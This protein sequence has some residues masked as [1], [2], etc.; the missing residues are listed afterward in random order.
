MIHDSENTEAAERVVRQFEKNRFFEGKL[1]TARDMQIEQ[2]YHTER[3][4]LLT[5]HTTGSGIV[6]GLEVSEIQN[7]GETIDVSIESGFA[8]DDYVRPIVVESATTKSLTASD[9]QKLL[10]CIRLD[11][12]LLE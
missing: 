5:R 11:E 1:M 6:Y 4:E 12:V 10:V 9:G 7:N 8:I 3:L 2:A